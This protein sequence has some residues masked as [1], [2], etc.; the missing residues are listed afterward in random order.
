MWRILGASRGKRA[1]AIPRGVRTF[2]GRLIFLFVVGV[3]IPLVAVTFFLRSAIQT[4]S[5]QDTLDHGRT[6]LIT[7]RRVLDDY[8]AS[9][10]S[11]L[12]VLDDLLLTWLSNAVGYDLTVYAPDSTLVATSRRDLYAAGLVPDRVPAPAFVAIGL[13]GAG[14]QAGARVVSGGR[15]EEITTAL[16]AVPGVPGV[17]SPGILSLLLL[18]QRRVAE[19]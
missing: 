12:A 2:R 15:F 4:R 10:C 3:M 1:E 19:A 8:L 5:E 18:P 7:A 13:A 9:E 6:A 16:E 11:P 17:R 14:E